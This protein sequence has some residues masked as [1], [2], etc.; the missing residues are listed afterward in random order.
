M[1]TGDKIKSI[2]EEHKHSQEQFAELLGV[3]RQSV[4][5]WESDKNFPELQKQLVVK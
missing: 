2:R 3:T 5:K 1:T 4:S